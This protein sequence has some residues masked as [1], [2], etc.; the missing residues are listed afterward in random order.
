MPEREGWRIQVARERK[1]PF[2]DW[3]Y[4]RPILGRFDGFYLDA[5]WALATE[6]RFVEASIPESEIR[7][8]AERYGVAP[9]MMD[10][11]RY[12]IRSLE[13]EHRKDQKARSKKKPA[14]EEGD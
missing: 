12:V 6:R 8:H 13:D 5:Y 7:K 9:Y 1:T 14:K 11:F 10:H 4:D 2:P 3:Y